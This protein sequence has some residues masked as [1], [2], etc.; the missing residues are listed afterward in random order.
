MKFIEDQ[1][2]IYENYVN[3]CLESLEFIL[4]LMLTFFRDIFEKAFPLKSF[5]E[6]IIKQVLIKTNMEF[7]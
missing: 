6:N 5:V 7:L 4:Q 3:F 2:K 1:L